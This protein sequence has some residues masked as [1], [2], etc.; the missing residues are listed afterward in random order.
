[1]IGKR[2]RSLPFIFAN[3][4]YTLRFTGARGT[5]ENAATATADLGIACAQSPFSDRN[6][7]ICIK[8]KRKLINN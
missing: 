3:D 4:N 7:I 8:K 6:W 2:F 1:M 5:V